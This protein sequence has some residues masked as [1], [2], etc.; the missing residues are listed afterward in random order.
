MPDLLSSPGYPGRYRETTPYDGDPTS[1][2]RPI[3]GRWAEG[4][5]EENVPPMY[6]LVLAYRQ[7]WKKYMSPRR[8]KFNVGLGAMEWSLTEVNRLCM[9][10]VGRRPDHYGAY[11]DHANLASWCQREAKV[12]PSQVPTPAVAQPANDVGATSIE[13]VD[14]L[15][16]LFGDE[17]APGSPEAVP[18]EQALLHPKKSGGTRAKGR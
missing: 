16:N 9:C 14:P 7:A 18:A 11:A 5:G 1:L 17:P 2:I 3:L 15:A 10:W 8:K 4:H 13:H 12:K 6:L